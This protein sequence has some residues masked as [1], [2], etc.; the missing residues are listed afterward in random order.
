MVRTAILKSRNVKRFLL[1][2]L[3]SLG[4]F[5]C[6]PYHSVHSHN[7]LNELD[8]AEINLNFPTMYDDFIGR[9]SRKKVNGVFFSGITN[10]KLTFFDN[11]NKKFYSA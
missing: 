3:C 8:C 5:S 7:A 9:V 1:M 10:Y 2:R 6:Y 11:F 4:V